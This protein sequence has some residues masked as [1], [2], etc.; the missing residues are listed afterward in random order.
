MGKIKEKFATF[1]NFFINKKKILVL[2]ASLILVLSLVPLHQTHAAWFSLTGIAG[3]I[4]GFCVFVINYIISTLF[5]FVVA[6][7]GWFI[8]VILQMNDNVVNSVLVQTGFGVSLAIANLGFVLAIVVIAIA[9]IIRYESYG[10]RQTLW[11][12][13]VAAILVNFSLVIAGSI[14]NLSNSF[15]KYFLT[16]L[17][18]QGGG[19][20][21]V[22][23]TSCSFA[24]NMA[25]LYQPQQFIAPDASGLSNKLGSSDVFSGLAAGTGALFGNAIAPIVSLFLA[26]FGLFLMV[27]V[28]GVLVALLLIRYVALSLLLVVMPF[29]WLFWIFP[30]T[31]NNWSRWWST[32][33]RWCIFA[34]IVLFF[35]YLV[36]ATGASIRN[37]SPGNPYSGET[38]GF[39][40]GSASILVSPIS[41]FLG[42]ALSPIV[43][44]FLD[45]IVLM[46]LTVGGLVMANSMSL[47]G[48]SAVIN[49]GRSAAS[50]GAV[51]GGRKAGRA[52]TYPL[53]TERGKK[54][55]ESVREVKL[56]AKIGADW[57]KTGGLLRRTI[58]TIGRGV[59]APVRYVGENAGP[60]AARGFES[61][62]ISGGAGMVETANS[63]ARKAG[64]SDDYSANNFSTQ[65]PP[66]Q[67]ATLGRL[68][69]NGNLDKLK[70]LIP[71]LA[72]NPKLGQLYQQEK[73][74][75]DIDKAIGSNTTMR[76]LAARLENEGE[77]AVMT[78]DTGTTVKDK[79]GKEVK[80]GEKYLDREGKEI[81]I[82]T[83]LD[84]EA[85]EFAKKY[86]KG[87]KVQWNDINSGK[88]MFGAS[89]QQMQY[90]STA[91]N[92]GI[93]TANPQLISTAIGKIKGLDNIDNFGKSIKDALYS[94]GVTLAKA[95]GANTSTVERLIE[96]AK[97]TKDSGEREA[98]TDDILE[99]F[100]KLSK[101]ITSMPFKATLS[102]LDKINKTI[103][104]NTIGFG[105]YSTGSKKNEGG[106]EAPLATYT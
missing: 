41:N 96:S 61:L 62:A 49:A 88:E 79:D 50:W 27:I 56:G 14:I 63:E 44:T 55:Q 95:E 21:S 106:E 92:K 82:K 60:Y 26:G 91:L 8:Q 23:P 10:L 103:I 6:I 68:L 30:I 71:Y 101:G 65:T 64:W 38:P 78:N 19:C 57:G 75:R 11:R 58:G 32:F 4:I 2:L 67:I 46:G 80:P 93:A 15:S 69:A 83:L 5:G 18:G 20:S 13:I 7:E 48:A 35:L 89:K 72:S 104:S 100:K 97:N 9:T 84:E 25:A 31:R 12:L 76:H 98:I 51:W 42:N 28:L 40:S 94:Q 39:K 54:V 73:L 99:E 105:D 33:I 53:R 90:L 37:N 22:D 16:G 1:Q 17:P 36:I 85:L 66:Q 47:T 87:D 24:M 52:L 81:K 102:R 43:G 86:G 3:G 70:S 29:A 45:A 74:F 59:T 34:P 77:N